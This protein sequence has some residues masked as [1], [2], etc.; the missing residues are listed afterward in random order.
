M[1]HTQISPI[2]RKE[3]TEMGMSHAAQNLLALAAAHEDMICAAQDRYN[4]TTNLYRL[5]DRTLRELAGR[6]IAGNYPTLKNVVAEEDVVMFGR[7]PEE[8]A[9]DK[10][11][12]DWDHDP[13]VYQDD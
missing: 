6:I 13:L 8:A 4:G 10:E 3:E 7:N 1:P 11:Y 9:M 2:T 12:E 5:A